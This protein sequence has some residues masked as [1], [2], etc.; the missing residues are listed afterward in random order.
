MC[1]ARTSRK[2]GREETPRGVE[3]GLTALGEPSGD[4]LPGPPCGP[5]GGREGGVPF[6]HEPGMFGNELTVAVGAGQ[7]HFSHRQSVTSVTAVFRGTTVKHAAS[8][9]PRPLC[10]ISP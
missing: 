1:S 10:V 3:H 9:F 4:A 5:W 8:H 2:R 6:N 7:S